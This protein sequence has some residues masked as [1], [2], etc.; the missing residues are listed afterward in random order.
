MSNNSNKHTH[1]ENE[2]SGTNQMKPTRID[3]KYLK[4]KKKIVEHMLDLFF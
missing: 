1:N 3:G 2:N 4:K